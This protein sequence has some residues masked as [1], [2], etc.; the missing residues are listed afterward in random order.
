MRSEN[1]GENQFREVWTF[2]IE[3]YDNAGNR[4]LLMPVE[5]RAR[6]FEGSISDGDW[7]RARG[8]V[9]SG[10]LRITRLENLTTGAFVRARGLSKAEVVVVCI[11]VLAFL[12][13]IGF[14]VYDTITTSAEFSR[15]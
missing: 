13:F 15:P 11:F 4:I 5:M 8:R 14:M 9:R 6:T 3:R 2:R 10:T 12:A 1:R 7:V